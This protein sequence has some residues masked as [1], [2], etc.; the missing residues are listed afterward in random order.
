[1]VDLLGKELFRAGLGVIHTLLHGLYAGV[2]V[3]QLFNDYLVDLRQLI[4]DARHSVVAGGN[5]Q[6]ALGALGVDDVLG[7]LEKCSVTS[8]AS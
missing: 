5:D 8:L 3:L 4:G 1:M 6:H 7:A 2:D